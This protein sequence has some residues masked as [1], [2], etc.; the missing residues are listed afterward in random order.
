MKAFFIAFLALIYAFLSCFEVFG[1]SATAFLSGSVTD[2]KN[3]VV[4]NAAVKIRN[5]R[6]AFERAAV[7]NADGF[8]V[9]TQ[10]P[11]SEYVLIVE[12]QGFAVSETKIVL[13]VN[14]QRSLRVQ[15]RVAGASA[16]VDVSAND[17]VKESPA[18][19]TVINRQFIANQ[20]LNG[21]SFQNLVELSPGVVIT[22]SNLP[23]PGQFSVNGQRTNSNYLTVDGVSGNFG[24][25]AATIPYE[26]GGSFP[27]LSVLGTTTS[28]VSV[29]AV[30]EFSIQT[31]AYA[32]E[33]GRQP[34]GQISLVTRGGTNRF[35]GT[36]FYYHRNEIF[37]ANNFFANANRLK[38][39]P[40]RQHNYG[41]VLGGPIL[42]DRTFFFVSYEGLR[43]RQPFVTNP[44]QVPSLTARANATGVLRDLL[45]AFPLPT[46]P[47]LPGN[48][49]VAP[50]LTNFTNPAKLDAVSF[51]IDHTLNSKFSI[52][53]RYNYSPSEDQQ[54]ARF[55]ATSCYGLITGKTQTLTIGS[56]MVFSSK[57]VNDLRLNWS[58]SK[59][60]QTYFLDNF[61]GAIVPPKSSLYPSFTDGPN[62]YIYIE[63]SPSG[64]NTLSDGLFSDTRNRQF[65]VVNTL[66]Y[67]IGNH[68]LKFGADYRRISTVSFAGNYRRLFL[69]G[70]IQALVQ[71]A[72]SP[73]II[74]APSETRPVYDNF[75]AFV[76]D[77]WRIK[78]NLTLT[79]GIRYE[80]VPAPGEANGNLPPT[81][82]SNANLSTATLVQNK[83][84][85]ETTYNNFAPRI[86]VA[87][88][89]PKFEI[90]IRGGFGVFYDLGYGFSSNAFNPSIFPFASRVDLSN[91]TYTSPSFAQPAPP[92]NFNPPFARIFAYEDNY[93]L[94]Y[95]LQYNL[96]VEKTFGGSNTISVGYVGATGKRLPRVEIVRNPNPTFVRIDLTTNGAKSDYNAL[97]VQYQ[98]RLSRGLQAI[99][100]YSFAKS[101]DT[102]SD[103]VVGNLQ[104]P[105]GRF[106]ENIDR[107]PST[108]DVRHAFNSAISYE[109]PAPFKSGIGKAIFGGFGLDATFR[110]RTATP[111][112]V[113]SGVNRFNLGVTTILRPD[114]VP[115]QPLYINDPSAPGGRRFNRDAFVVPPAS[116][117]RQGTFG[118]NVMRG[119]GANQLD[120]SL[121]RTF[122]ITETVRLQMRIDGFNIF[123]RANFANPTGVLTSG[124]FGRATQLLANGLGGLSASYQIGGPRSF[125]L[126]ARLSF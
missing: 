82:N 106:P 114:Y 60:N 115:G 12:A 41:G 24:T 111:V 2:E 70:S 18:V 48:P 76:Q 103:E 125:Q 9:F 26:T 1:Q 13:N 88:Q 72:P 54:R 63:V 68:A 58:K 101:L 92:V 17:F 10:L 20:P 83:K 47:S 104:A 36:V 21:R 22:P 51:R 113:V 66:S 102:V 6:T 42:R 74:V 56:T 69:P 44:L 37:D 75:S 117:N 107:G 105:T 8:F 62:G 32:P 123:N 7:T 85:Y 43:L 116:E 53:G 35:S 73:G 38:R 31:S 79:Y 28:L 112:N 108:F 25:V 81:I 94:P 98:R 86:G 57:I 40:L 119:F 16:I 120:L 23:S 67:N 29:D 84:F 27:S 61:G 64:D 78:P 11:P 45:N 118:R 15:M 124:N 34:G 55:C 65:N 96:T 126:S 95:T 110:A 46:G 14:D 90:T 30:Q 97:Q 49:D 39:Q 77:A 121:R 89:M 33:F 50:Y 93:K 100:S 59:S 71:N 91:I 4:R 5:E 52:F 109:I 99:A 19:S 87:Y 80:V 3:A 122:G